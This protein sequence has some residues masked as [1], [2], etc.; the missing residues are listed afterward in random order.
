MVTGY[1]GTPLAK[2]LGV[3]AGTF[4]RLIAAPNGFLEPNEGWT[5]VDGRFNVAVAFCLSTDEVCRALALLEPSLDPPGGIWIAWPKRASGITTDCS[6]MVV[7]E[8][9]LATGL[10]D[11][12][13]CAIDETWSALRFAKRLEGKK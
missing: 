7:R 8:L 4:L 6:D 9:G 2:K 5:A 13:V 12:K 1:S 11:N 3:K 10:V